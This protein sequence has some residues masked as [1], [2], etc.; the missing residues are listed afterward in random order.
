MGVGW[1]WGWGWNGGWKAR[2]QLMPRGPWSIR[3]LVF[4]RGACLASTSS[5]AAVW[6]MTTC[7]DY[8]EMAAWPA[9]DL[10]AAQCITA[11]DKGRKSVLFAGHFSWP[12]AGCQAVP[13]SCSLLAGPG[14][15]KSPDFPRKAPLC[16]EEDLLP[17]LS[18]LL[19][20]FSVLR[21]PDSQSSRHASLPYFPLCLLTHHP[22]PLPPSP[23][24]Y[25]VSR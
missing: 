23:A 7:S 12:G 4:S 15:R 24:S 5:R 11:D 18:P 9:N 14:D 2:L 3:H 10:P 16:V 25:K 1:G 6:R 20:L 21:G 13:D 17:V 8:N 22:L 19:F